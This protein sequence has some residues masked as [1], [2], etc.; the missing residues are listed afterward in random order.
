MFCLR[1]YAAGDLGVRAFFPV[2]GFAR[3]T[4]GEM[5]LR[6]LFM[7]V[8]SARDVLKINSDF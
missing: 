5:Y 2:M 8:S 3:P 1:L 7:P 4:V 6:P